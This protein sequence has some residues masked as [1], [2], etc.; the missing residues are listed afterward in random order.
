MIPKTIVLTVLSFIGWVVPT[1]S[2]PQ[3]TV[4]HYDE[5][6]GMAQWYV[7][8]IVQDKQG[9]MWF[10]TWNGLNRYDGYEFVNFKSHVGDRVDMPSDRIQ[11]IMLTDEGNLLCFVDDRPY[12]FDLRSYRFKAISGNNQK[13]LIAIFRKRHNEEIAN[14]L[15]PYYIHKDLY[16]TIW[17]IGVDGAVYQIDQTT[18]KPTEYLPA[19]REM[20]DVHYCMTD[21]NGNVWLRSHYG[22]YRLSFRQPP[23]LMFPQEK[24]SQIRFFYLDSHQR[25]WVTS[26]DDATIRLF[27]RNNRLLGYLGH[28]GRLH[29]QYTSF[30]SSVYAMIQDS[31]GFF[32]LG[33]RFDGLFRL[34]E[35]ET[36]LFRIDN[37]T[38]EEN[39]PRSLS[40][41]SVYDIKEDCQGRLW[42]ASFDGGLN[43]IANPH[44]DQPAFLNKDNGIACPKETCLR[45]RQIH[46]TAD[47]KLL[48]ATT[49][50]LLVADI[51][52]KDV[53]KIKF[54]RHVKETDRS[55]SLSNNA[56]MYVAE[57]AKHR[58][59]VCTES[60]G[61]NQIISDNLLA[62]Q[63]EFR[64][65]NVSTGLP[66]DVAL[67]AIPFGLKLLIVSNNQ[68]IVLNPD[69][70]DKAEYE[71]FLWKEHLRF[72]DATPLKLPDGK[73]LFGLQEAAFTI[74][75]ENMTK[76]DFVPPI[77]LSGFSV[78]NG[79]IDRSI[80]MMD[81]LVLT[82]P[83]RD[84]YLQFAALDYT[85]DGTID[86]AFRL[87]AGDT[88]WNYIGKD[89]SATLL[90]VKPGIY[91]LQIRST[92]GDG[93]WGDNIRTLTLIVKPTFWETIWAQLLYILL[94]GIFIG[95]VL[96][97]RRY[98]MNLK[99]QQNEL[100]EA[101]L[102]L[103][104][105]NQ[106]KTGAHE[107][108]IQSTKSN[109]KPEDEAF[110][111]RAMKFIEE[112]LGDADVNIGD[113]ADATA[114]SRSGLNRKMKSLLG[115]TPLDFIHEA[116]IR[117][118]CQMLKAG[119]PVI[120]V[121][122]NCGFSDPKYFGKCFKAAMGMTPTEYKVENSAN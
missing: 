82:P 20:K 41:N 9:M 118:A 121:A 65:F 32:W 103:M 85:S 122:Y 49:S 80:N 68:L 52:S 64:H 21:R 117:K 74:S 116:R 115:V 97:T 113:M 84:I 71:A 33:T 73:Y 93:V 109:I 57:D 58:L 14:D 77:A 108:E 38:H 50:G 36:G 112:H 83:Q 60:G 31:Q 120:D 59:F 106:E 119:M 40:N 62:E 88:P 99:R 76:S 75:P 11:D 51:S 90:D 27:D 107:S 56:T 66:S 101:Y 79:P 15:K 89:H 26:K 96:Y 28:D 91:Q 4:T 16:G 10:A 23:Y 1:S 70:S 95:T 98:I 43:C 94:M 29:S 87:T 7:T 44:M 104:N 3:C 24:P 12:L 30:L 53:S 61:V 54:R 86:Y 48:A 46:L 69:V 45:M 8:Q 67:S 105:A 47:D 17:R 72:S 2:Q 81:T 78:E 92:N 55:S 42:I 39:N 22:A 25:Y 18:S 5:F 35:T 6:S 111:Q 110:M 114:T 19:G 100:H 63:L 34:E 37:F 13:D 102:N